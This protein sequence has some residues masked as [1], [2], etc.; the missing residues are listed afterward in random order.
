M[1]ALDH[2]DAPRGRLYDSILETVGHTPLV[3]LNRVAE[4]AGALAN[5][6]AKLE[7]FNPLSSIKDRIALSMIEAAE[8]DGTLKPGMTLVE[9]TSGNTGIGLALVFGGDLLQR[10]TFL[11]LVDGVALEAVILLGQGLSRISV[12]GVRRCDAGKSH[13]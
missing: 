12:H 4:Q 10:R 9:P 2:L 13:H 11:G 7:F 5:V 1:S 8:R 6:Y 3:K